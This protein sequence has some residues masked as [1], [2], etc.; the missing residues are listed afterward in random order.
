MPDVIVGRVQVNFSPVSAA[1]IQHVRAAS[2]AC[3]PCCRRNAARLCPRFR[4]WA[5]PVLPVSMFLGWL[6]LFAPAK[7]PREVVARLNAAMTATLAAPDVRALL[8]Q[9][10]VQAEGS[11]PQAL[12]AL[13][14][15][16]VRTWRVFILEHGLV[17]E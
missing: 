4:P 7:T 12:A 8:E 3:S 16:D 6:G 2:C 1:G 11:T 15:D 10:S 13:I 9:Q 17:P 14:D 5:K